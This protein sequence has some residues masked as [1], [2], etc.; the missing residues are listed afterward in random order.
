M[1]NMWICKYHGKH[2]LSLYPQNFHWNCSIIYI[3]LLYIYRTNKPNRP[4]SLHI[5]KLQMRPCFSSSSRLRPEWLDGLMVEPNGY[6]RLEM[7]RNSSNIFYP[8]L[9]YGAAI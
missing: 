3:Q 6:V 5:V 1:S 4:I 8:A 2:L 7:I 9:N